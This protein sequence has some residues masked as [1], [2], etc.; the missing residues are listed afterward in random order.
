MDEQAI[1]PIGV[2]CRYYGMSNV[3]LRSTGE[4]MGSGGNQCALILEAHA[5]CRMET[6][7]FPPDESVC[8]LAV[9]YSE[10]LYSEQKEKPAVELC[11]CG[12]PL[13]Y[14]SQRV[15]AWVGEEIRLLGPTVI[16]T[17]GGRSWRVPR[18]YIALHGLK[19]RDVAGLGFEEI[20]DG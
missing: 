20:T 1:A 8:P 17:V 12:Q 16:V 15:A 6:A 19:G 11:H 9:R 18:H 3:F 4:L 7:G 13:H 5:P 10:K 2:G 14:T